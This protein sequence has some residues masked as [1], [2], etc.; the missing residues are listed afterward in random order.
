[1]GKESCTWRRR[2]GRDLSRQV[3]ARKRLSYAAL[4]ELFQVS[5]QQDPVEQGHNLIYLQR[6]SL[7]L[8][9]QYLDISRIKDRS[10]GWIKG[11]YFFLEGGT[12]GWMSNR[13]LKVKMSRKSEESPV[14]PTTLNYSCI[15]I[16][17][18]VSMDNRAF[19]PHAHPPEKRPTEAVASFQQAPL[20][21]GGSQ[22]SS[23]RSQGATQRP[24]TRCAAEF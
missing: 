19:G 23:E 3:W 17:R 14:S 24:F 1:M 18:S 20:R 5:R 22:V 12:I 21:R 10:N 11:T 6:L 15:G 2:L 16:R 4:L 8:L 7:D 13:R 9:Y